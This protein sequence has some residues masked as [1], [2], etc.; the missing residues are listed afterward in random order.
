MTPLALGILTLLGLLSLSAALGLR[1]QRLAGIRMDSRL[2]RGVLC[3]TLGLG[4][5]QFFPF[6]LFALG[7]GSALYFRLGAV[8]LAI[9]LLPEMLL[10]ARSLPG[11]ARSVIALPLWQRFL[12]GVFGLLFLSVL[13]RAFC[14]ITDDDGLS[15][16]M[17]AAVR[18]LQAER[19]I[20]IPTITPT[21]WPLGVES[22]F[23]LVIGIHPEAPPAIVP[24]VLG[25]LIAGA[26][27]VL[28]RRFGGAAGG[29][30]ALTALLAYPLMWRLMTYA[31]VDLGGMLFATAGVICLERGLKTYS[32]RWLLLAAVFAGLGATTKLTGFYIVLA[33]VFVVLTSGPVRAGRDR[34][35]Q[36]ALIAAVGFLPL[37]PWLARTWALTGNPI[38]PLFHGLLGGIEYTAEG[39]A[40][41]QYCHLLF[42]TPPGM[43][44]TPRTIVLAHAAV[45]LA[46]TLI[47]LLTFR[48][49]R[50]SPLAIPLR[51]AAIFTAGICFGSYFNPRFVI[52]ALP[53]IAAY[54]GFR[55][56]RYER[57]L[58]PVVCAIAAL[59]ALRLG[60]STVEPDLA[61]SWNVA[62]GRMSKQDYLAMKVGDYEIAQYANGA[63][64]PESRILVGTWEKNTTHYR[65][66]AYWP[67]Y[68]LQD[69]VH[70]ESQAR[71]ESDLRRM[72]IT[73]VVFR[74]I[75]FEWCE[76]SY[77]CRGRRDAETPALDQ[78]T[79]RRGRLLHRAKG[80]SLYEI[81][82][83]ADP[84]R[85]GRI[86]GPDG[87]R[88]QPE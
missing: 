3:T 10:I 41:Y 8:A 48:Q 2:E 28:A 79:Q 25:I 88:E 81:D 4:L 83:N 86:P 42:N 45:A 31:H 68:W 9:G 73:H 23:A 61:T 50:S 24:F 46:G 5:L 56:C 33:M 39:W 63:L 32:H 64:K 36:G 1:I 55:L 34:V 71:L 43:P 70:Y 66:F 82:F 60:V 57:P 44:P 7:R 14:P 40:R 11:L 78:L 6:V 65:S 49:T 22:L 29:W 35:K 37:I 84:L 53:P 74:P 77:V 47:A 67:D 85:T 69:A 80:V 12:T 75:D 26:A 21:N 38:Y 76:K 54:V 13:P 72:G 18:Y 27:F 30:I 51:F 59:L 87:R 15:Y 58:A 20:Y 17:S 19:F 16:H 62:S 52:A